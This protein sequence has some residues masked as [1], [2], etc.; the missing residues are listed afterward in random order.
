[1]AAGVDRRAT[2]ISA[3]TKVKMQNTRLQI[4]LTNNTGVAGGWRMVVVVV[5]VAAVTCLVA[6]RVLV[7]HFRYKLR[8][9]TLDAAAGRSRAQDKASTS[10]RSG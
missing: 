6:T 4:G 7:L 10:V 2:E 9:T 3:F 1:M 8:W 5:V